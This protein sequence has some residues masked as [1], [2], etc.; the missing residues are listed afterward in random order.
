M[1]LGNDPEKLLFSAFSISS[2]KP[3]HKLGGSNPEKLLRPSL[4]LL[5][6]GLR[7]PKSLGMVPEKL[8]LKTEND[9]NFVR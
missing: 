8:L 4:T 5:K 9:F 1:H 3:L 6:K 2:P 7:L